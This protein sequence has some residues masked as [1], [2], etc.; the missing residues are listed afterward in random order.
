M[1]ALHKACLYI[2]PILLDQWSIP[3]N[4]RDFYYYDEIPSDLREYFEE[5]PGGMGVRKN[6]HPT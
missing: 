4:M 6:S 1:F 2:R 3:H 5:V